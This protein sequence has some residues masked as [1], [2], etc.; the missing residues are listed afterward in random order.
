MTPDPRDELVD[1]LDADG[2][3][4]GTATRREV[5]ARGLSHR[6]TCVLVFNIPAPD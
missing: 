4:I 2:R 5:R 6:C 1:V 3:V